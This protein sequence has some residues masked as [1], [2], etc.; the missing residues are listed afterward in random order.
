MTILV[1]RPVT[2]PDVVE[3]PIVEGALSRAMVGDLIGVDADTITAY[4]RE[5]KPDG[6]YA[7]DPFPANDDT[8]SG[9]P[10]W[11]PKRAPE[12]EAWAARR[13]RHGVGGRPRSQP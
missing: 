5:S 7:R 1:E 8:F 6:R 2:S 3:G 9:R 13:P 4:Q 12:I 11:N 10:W